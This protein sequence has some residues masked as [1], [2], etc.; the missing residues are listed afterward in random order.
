MMTEHQFRSKDELLKLVE[1]LETKLSNMEALKND[2]LLQAWARWKMA[3]AISIS[4]Q[5]EL[6]D[7]K[8]AQH[9]PV[10]KPVLALAFRPITAWYRL[11]PTENDP[12][13]FSRDY[14]HFEYYHITD[15]LPTLNGKVQSGKWDKVHKFITSGNVIVDK[16]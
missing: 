3:N 6:A 2:E 14:N 16:Q 10:P 15:P 12:T 11:V 13:I 8:M 1:L 4:V 5:N 7:I 9:V